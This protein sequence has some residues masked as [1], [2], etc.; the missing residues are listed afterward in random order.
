MNLIRDD[1]LA[2]SQSHR[3]H[4][5][6]DVRHPA[7]TRTRAHLEHLHS[8]IVTIEIIA[9]LAVHL[10]EIV[11]L[12]ACSDSL[13]TPKEKLNVFLTNIKLL[14][15]FIH[16][17]MQQKCPLDTYQMKFVVDMLAKII[18]R[19]DRIVPIHCLNQVKLPVV[20]NSALVKHIKLGFVHGWVAP[21]ESN[22]SE[23]SEMT[24]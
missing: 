22:L 24:A 16:H 18:V 14:L 12:L 2:L 3:L 4:W 9:K 13:L 19:N 17:L 1:S 10:E 8:V 6:A 11:V 21:S 23:V 5:G 20:D 15:S 7:W